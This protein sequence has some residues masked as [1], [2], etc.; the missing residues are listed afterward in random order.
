M[1]R[2]DTP[3]DA[4]EYLGRSRRSPPFAGRID[5]TRNGVIVDFKTGD[6]DLARHAEQLRFYAALW[7]LRFGELPSG[8]E[9]RYPGAVHVIPLPDNAEVLVIVQMLVRELAAI[10]DAMRTPPLRANPGAELCKHCPVRQL[11]DAY[12]DA[13]DTRSLRTLPGGG[14]APDGPPPIRDIALMRFPQTIGSPAANR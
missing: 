13:P 12:W 8:L 14:Q 10:T 4:Q 6:E 7:R 2:P 3:R 11:C 1:Q 5:E 9:I